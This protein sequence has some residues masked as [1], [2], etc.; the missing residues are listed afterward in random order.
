MLLPGRDEGHNLRST[1]MALR[2][3]TDDLL[4][5]TNDGDGGQGSNICRVKA[6]AKALPLFS[7]R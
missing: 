7:H 1:S 3:G 5:V 4:I 2:P 6:F